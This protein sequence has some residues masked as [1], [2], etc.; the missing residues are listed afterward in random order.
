MQLAH[1]SYQTKVGKTLGRMH[2]WLLLKDVPKW[3]TACDEDV[4]VAT[5][6]LRA[7]EMGAYSDSS[8]PDTPTTP[9]TPYTPITLVSEDIPNEE[10]VGYLAQLVERLQK[11]RRRRKWRTHM[12][13]Y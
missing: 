12:W 1:E 4:E 10:G 13:R 11:E 6:R 7:N 3:E 8:S 2:W 9:E 5:K